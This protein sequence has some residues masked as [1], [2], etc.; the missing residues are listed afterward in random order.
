MPNDDRGG[1]E[2][3][4]REPRDGT[5]DDTAY[6]LVYVRARPWPDGRPHTAS[7]VQ[8]DFEFLGESLPIEVARERRQALDHHGV[9]VLIVPARYRRPAVDLE[10]AGARSEDAVREAMARDPALDLAAPRL[11]GDHPMYYTFLA[12]SERMERA[13]QTFPP[14]VLISIDKCDGHVW[15]AAELNEFLSLVS[16]RQS[17]G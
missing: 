10:V 9:S 15:T 13:G 14:G 12:V 7:L 8:L 3:A 5:D 16:T 6:D 17:A 4:V 11:Y 2:A 1:A